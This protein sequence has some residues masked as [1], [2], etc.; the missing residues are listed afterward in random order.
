MLLP[1]LFGDTNDCSMSIAVPWLWPFADSL[2][3]L[4]TLTAHIND[5]SF[6][7]IITKYK[8][9]SEKNKAAVE[10]QLGVKRGR[11]DTTVLVSKRLL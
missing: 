2:L 6:N 3:A 8:Q 7:I 11:D 5:V 4:I 10:L 9:C 1:T